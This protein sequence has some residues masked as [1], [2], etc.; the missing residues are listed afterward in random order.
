MYYEDDGHTRE[1]RLMSKERYRAGSFDACAEDA[2]RQLYPELY[3]SDQ[4]PDGMVICRVCGGNGFHREGCGLI[5]PDRKDKA[6][7]ED[8][9]K[10]SNSDIKRVTFEELEA[11]EAKRP[12]V[13]PNLTDVKVEPKDSIDGASQ[14]PVSDN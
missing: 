12:D 14:E 9:L 5:N 6:A 11:E 13:K 3:W 7:I 1:E 10:V 4:R 2:K 8:L